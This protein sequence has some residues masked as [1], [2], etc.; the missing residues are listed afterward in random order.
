MEQGKLLTPEKAG[1][2]RESLVFCIFAG[3]NTCTAEPL[4]FIKLVVQN[5]SN[6]QLVRG[7]IVCY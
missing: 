5:T 3:L 7:K 4:T 6:N 2:K 1:L